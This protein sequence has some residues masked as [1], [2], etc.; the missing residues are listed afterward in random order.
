MY[1]DEITTV[2][3]NSS[4]LSHEIEVKPQFLEIRIFVLISCSFINLQG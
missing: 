1:L 4:I 3:N 2:I